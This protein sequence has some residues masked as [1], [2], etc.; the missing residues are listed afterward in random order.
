MRQNLTCRNIQTREYR[1]SGI[2]QME[3]QLSSRSPYRAYEQGRN[4]RDEKKLSELSM[5]YADAIKGLKETRLNQVIVG[6]VTQYCVNGK[7]FFSQ[8]IWTD[9]IAR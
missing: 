5:L 8:L 4:Y 6:D 2:K 7:D 3:G 1:C 9:T